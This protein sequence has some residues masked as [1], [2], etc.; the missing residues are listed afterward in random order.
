MID[1]HDPVSVP[2]DTDL[3]NR[4]AIEHAAQASHRGSRTDK[5]TSQLDTSRSAKCIIS[6]ELAVNYLSKDVMLMS[7]TAEAGTGD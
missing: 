2:S 6:L 3:D 4:A 7:G 1:L 5:S